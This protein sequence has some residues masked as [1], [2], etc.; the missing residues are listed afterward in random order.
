MNFITGERLQEFAEATVALNTENNFNSE[1]VKTQIKNTKTKCYV[2][3]PTRTDT[4]IPDDL[5]YAKSIFTYPHILD[6]FFNFVYPQ[7]EGPFTLI[8]HNSDVGITS[9]FHP[10]L[11]SSKI[12]KWYCQNKYTSHPKLFSIPIGIANS[13]WPHGNLQALKQTIENNLEKNNLVFKS[14]DCSTNTPVRLQVNTETELNGFKMMN[15]MPFT[16]YIQRLKQSYFCIAPPGN[17][18]DCHRIWECLY[19]GCVPIIYKH[20]FSFTEFSELPIMQIDSYTQITESFLKE[21]IKEFY[22]FNKFNF[23]KL[24]LNYW[25]EVITNE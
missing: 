3:S 25:K 14:F 17:G 22:P 10:F 13:Q 7:L 18:A 23:K 11:D 6:Y 24:D 2:F 4:K 16:Q 5:K 15:P 19:L 21:K 8:T 12:K 20:P 9:N 1:L